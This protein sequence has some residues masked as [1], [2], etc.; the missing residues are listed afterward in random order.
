MTT[1]RAAINLPAAARRPADA[2]TRDRRFFTGMA[3]AIL[4]TVFVGFA[5]SYY[6]KIV[7]GAPGVSGAPI[8][9]PLIHVHG[10]AFT[11]WVLVFLVQTRLV[12]GRRLALHR[13]LGYAAA[14]LAVAMVVLGVMAAVDAAR[15][16][17][18]PPGGPP[19]LVFLIVPIADMVIFPILV[20]AGMWFR[21]RGEIHKRLMLVSTIALVTAA[22][23]R[24]PGVIRGGP[25]VYF[26]LTDLFVVAAMV[27]DRRT[28]GR[29]HPAYWWGGGGLLAS[30]AGRLALSGT[31]AWL[32]FATWL[33]ARTP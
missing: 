29:V 8:L 15:R 24:W 31:A 19:P 13:K 25:L 12:A 26:A 4:L 20:G 10:L 21:N 5:P 14:G 9:S 30:Q 23:A 28:R 27:Y 33:V 18:T 1:D 16:G 7:F 2:W 3:L 6:M 11:A 22:I 32:A 17:S